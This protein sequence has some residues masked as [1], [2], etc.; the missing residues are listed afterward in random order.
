MTP[1]TM[2]SA[3]GSFSTPVLIFGPH[4]AA[5]GVLRALTRRGVPAYVVVD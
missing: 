3:T 2:T 1:A 4:I 5:L